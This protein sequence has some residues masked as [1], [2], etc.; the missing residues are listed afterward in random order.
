ME[1]LDGGIDPLLRVVDSVGQVIAADDDSGG[2]YNAPIAGLAIAQA[3]DY[4]IQARR[5]GSGAGEYRLS[6]ARG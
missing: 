6:V 4:R 5:Y 3:G 2:N 1:S